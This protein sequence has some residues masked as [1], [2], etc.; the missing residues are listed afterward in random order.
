MG[1]RDD[2]LSTWGT[3]VLLPMSWPA[4]LL[5]ISQLVAGTPMW[6]F[7]ISLKALGVGSFYKVVGP[8]K[9]ANLFCCHNGIGQ[10]W[11]IKKSKNFFGQS[12][13]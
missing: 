7:C 2:L 4:S 12:P 3:P 8:M 6:C 13:F 5:E 11:R 10:K 1:P 9:E